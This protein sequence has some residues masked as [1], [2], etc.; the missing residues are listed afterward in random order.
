MSYPA[1]PPGPPGPPGYPPGYIP[2]LHLP[3]TL[4]PD[5]G[6]VARLQAQ[7]DIAQQATAQAAVAGRRQRIAGRWFTPEH[8][9]VAING[10]IATVGLTGYPAQKLG[11]I[12]Y[13]SLP[14]IGDVVTA[15]GPCGQV[16]STKAVSDLYAPVNGEVTAVN[17]E[18]DAEPG[19]INT[20][21]YG[22]GWMYRVRLAVPGEAALPPN[23]LSPA[24]YEELTKGVC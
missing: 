8:E 11:D 9:W 2:G 23:L 4:I 20:E 19:L 17:G 21:P 22:A 15:G 18:L 7:A 6:V 12:V 16:E 10:E 14:A 3:G 13:V 24:E 1:Y 5:P